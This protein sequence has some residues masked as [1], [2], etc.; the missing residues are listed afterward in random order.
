MITASDLYEVLFF[1]K[2]YL[3]SMSGVDPLRSEWGKNRQG[4]SPT[5]LFPSEVYQ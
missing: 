5:P 3:S 4:F 1:I 2:I